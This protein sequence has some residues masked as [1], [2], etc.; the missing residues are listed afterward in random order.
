MQIIYYLCNIEI[1]VI[2]K[3]QSFLTI[4]IDKTLVDQV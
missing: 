3:P 1:Y 2:L 4:L